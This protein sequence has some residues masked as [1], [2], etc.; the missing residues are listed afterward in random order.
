MN[1]AI[2]QHLLRVVGLNQK[3]IIRGVTKQ[4]RVGMFM[5]A[6][7]SYSGPS[8]LTPPPIWRFLGCGEIPKIKGDYFFQSCLRKARCDC[9]I[10]TT[11]QVTVERGSWIGHENCV[12]TRLGLL[13]INAWANAR[14]AARVQPPR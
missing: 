6:Y 3:Q 12:S 7:W 2:F 11:C 13:T 5:E 14:E 1:T 8:I 9:G 10:E 4:Y